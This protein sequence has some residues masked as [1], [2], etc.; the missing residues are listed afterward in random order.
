MDW[1]D[2]IKYDDLLEKDARIIYD[3]CGAD[4]LK[5][6]WEN[7]SGMTFYLSERSL[8]E[9]K[10]RYILEKKDNPDFNVKATAL[11]LK[12][13]ESFVYSTIKGANINERQ[14]KLFE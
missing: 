8:N 10:K 12:V 4:V 9:M 3:N 2:E 6:L 5:S 11:R 14:G 13:T 1:L 7:L